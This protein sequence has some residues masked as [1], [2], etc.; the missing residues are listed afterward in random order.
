M[1]E[2]PYATELK[3][4]G[5]ALVELGRRRAEVLCLSGDL[6]RQT[7]VDLFQAEFPDRFIHGGMAEANMMGMAGALARCGYL[8]FVHTFGS[9]PPAGPSTRSPTPSPTRTC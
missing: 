5:R 9:S 8:P 6:T 1:R 3:Q 7:E 2:P 4:Y